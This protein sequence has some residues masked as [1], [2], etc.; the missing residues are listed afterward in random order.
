MYTR[1]IL[2]MHAKNKILTKNKNNY[3]TNRRI[4]QELARTCV[5]KIDDSKF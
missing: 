4:E 2:I 1:Y 5:I 3:N